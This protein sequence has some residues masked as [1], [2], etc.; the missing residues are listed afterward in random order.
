MDDLFNQIKV[1]LLSFPHSKKTNYD[2]KISIR[3][4]FCGDSKKSNNSH[5]GLLFKENIIVYNC[6]R[7]NCG[8]KG[9]VNRDFL[10]LYN[11]DAKFIKTF[12]RESSLGKFKEFKFKIRGDDHKNDYIRKIKFSDNVMKDKLDYLNGRLN[13]NS[14]LSNYKIVLDFKDFFKINY[15]NYNSFTEKELYIIELLQKKYV[16]FVSWNNSLLICRNI[17]STDRKN[18]YY[19]FHFDRSNEK[20]TTYFIPKKI[21]YLSKK[22]R[23]IIAEGIFD[24]INIKNVFYKENNDNEIFAAINGI[25][26]LSHTLKL[27]LRLTGFFDSELFIYSDNDVKLSRYLDILKPFYFKETNIFINKDNKDF[28]Q[29]REGFNIQKIL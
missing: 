13:I 6:L 25:N 14:G 22:P 1:K 18:R 3:C 7:A 2:N 26:N 4:R 15:V 12:I 11:F 27:I 9:I 16:G 29:Y 5:L 24:L 17:D 23:I 21:D 10:K 28:G 20:S 8:K 19:N